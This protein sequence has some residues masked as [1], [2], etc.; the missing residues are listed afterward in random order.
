MPIYEFGN[1]WSAWD[2]ADLFLITTNAT[3][4]RDGSLVMGR[5]IAKEA[6]DRF[7]GLDL[8]LG[9][10]ITKTGDPYGIII[11]PDWEKWPAK[12]LGIFQVKS[13]YASPADLELIQIS[14]DML[15]MIAT[16]LPNTQIHLNY[17]GIGNGHL[18][19]GQV[20]PLIANLPETVHIWRKA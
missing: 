5:G 12:K 1:M 8:R 4:K 16:T 3:I 2:D 18:L 10:A 14:A 13:H 15:M 6:R 20:A 11:S 19:I 7:P 9:K 17:P